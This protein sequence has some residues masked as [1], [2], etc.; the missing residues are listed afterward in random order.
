[1]HLKFLDPP[2]TKILEIFLL[3]DPAENPLE[4]FFSYILDIQR[5][6]TF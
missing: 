4:N 6:L 5:Y 3:K 1:M 2:S